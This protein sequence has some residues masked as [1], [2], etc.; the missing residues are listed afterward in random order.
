MRCECLS[1]FLFACAI[2]ADCQ[3]CDFRMLSR[4][5]NSSKKMCNKVSCENAQKTFDTFFHVFST[6]FF[7]G[8]S[9]LCWA[10]PNFIPAN[11]GGIGNRGGKTAKR[12]RE[13]ERNYSLHFWQQKF[14]AYAYILGCPFFAVVNIISVRPRSG[15]AGST[16]MGDAH[17]F[18]QPVG[19]PVCLT[20]CHSNTLSYPAPIRWNL[21]GEVRKAIFSATDRLGY[22]LWRKYILKSIDLLLQ[23]LSGGG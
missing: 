8:S 17:P 12:E 9:R 3:S 23:V 13:R 10:A 19:L 5:Q 2:W 14:F 18:S 20:S 7:F 4:A 21:I 16:P 1:P 6:I 22:E 11:L 15:T